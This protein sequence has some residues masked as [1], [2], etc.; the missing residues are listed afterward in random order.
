MSELADIF[1]D[2]DMRE[3]FARFYRYAQVGRCVSSVTHDVNN[4]LG[5]ILAYAELLS[6][7]SGQTDESRRMLEE[8]MTA[9]RRSSRLVSSLT[10]IA[11]RERPDLRVVSPRDLLES[12]LDLRRY[13]LKMVRV[14]LETIYQEDLPQI[15]V[16][17]PKLQQALIYLLSNAIEAVEGE[18]D[19]RIKVSV[20]AGTATVEFCFWNAGGAIPEAVRARLFEP[21]FTTRGG[22]HLG[23]GLWT[24]RH[25]LRAFRGDVTYDPARGFSAVVPQESGAGPLGTENST[26]GA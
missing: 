7:E 18:K 3:R 20:S 24:A 9:V 1:A 4:Y 2:S 23:L 5:A 21:F 12:V 11:R 22:G 15:S 6:L 25:N 10:D 16:D 8:I 19:R 17:L 13:D 14:D 26:T